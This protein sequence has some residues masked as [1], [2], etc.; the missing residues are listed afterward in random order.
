M[1]M[2][3][4]KTDELFRKKL[5]NYEW[6]GDIPDW[7]E[8]EVRLPHP[9]SRVSFWRIAAAAVLV[10]GTCG[11]LTNLLIHQ[12]P[13]VDMHSQLPS[14][15]FQEEQ[16]SVNP[17]DGNIV[18]PN[19]SPVFRAVCPRPVVT[20]DKKNDVFAANENTTHTPTDTSTATGY[21]PD[22]PCLD[23]YTE[24]HY[25]LRSAHPRMRKGQDFSV[26]LA[27]S[28]F[29]LAAKKGNASPVISY[30]A[31]RPVQL[32][33]DADGRLRSGLDK[34]RLSGF[35]HRL[36][37]KVGVNASFGFLRMFSAETGIMYSYHHS[38]FTR[39][40]GA[41]VKGVQKLHFLGVPLNLICQFVGN[42]LYRFYAG[43]GAEVNLN[44]HTSQRIGFSGKE[45]MSDFRQKEPVWGAGVKLGAALR[46]I[47]NCE[48]YFE[49]ALM[50]YWSKG[51]LHL[52]WTDDRLTFNLNF[53]IRTLF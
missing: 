17:N 33:I 21:V 15:S 47:G 51:D 18:S 16:T 2:R 45:I 6:T 39:M 40:D 50:K 8:V 9:S 30:A 41:S 5:V 20:P 28:N 14:A 25:S 44:L 48:F 1:N 53:G 31:Y 27:A 37:I 10:L 29:T 35:N 42:D 4:D 38:D 11:W 49:P 26:G 32:A 43:A 19:V 3:K 23:A 12:T 13:S 24:N 36:P 34:N 46:V 22:Q 7:E 52:K